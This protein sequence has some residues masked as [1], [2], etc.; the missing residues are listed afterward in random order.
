M[1]QCVEAIERMSLPVP[2]LKRKSWSNDQDDRPAKRRANHEHGEHIP[3]ATDTNSNAPML[4]GAAPPVSI[5][6]RPSTGYS[7]SPKL[8]SAPELP[9]KRGRPSRADKAK[10]DLRPLLPQ[11]PDSRAVFKTQNPLTP[12]PTLPALAPALYDPL[13]RLVTHPDVYTPVAHSGVSPPHASPGARR[14]ST[15]SEDALH[16]ALFK[17]ERNA[18]LPDPSTRR[19]LVE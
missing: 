10:R 14:K 8:P 3:R 17:A 9:K 13:S 15:P 2:S 19:V 12:R 6:S 7:I 5:L 16:P 11:P 4:P 18:G 1:N